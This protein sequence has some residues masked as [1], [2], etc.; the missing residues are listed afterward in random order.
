V[1]AL[2]LMQHYA[3][4]AHDDPRLVKPYSMA[5]RTVVLLATK[6]RLAPSARMSPSVAAT[7]AAKRERLSAYDLMEMEDDADDNN[8]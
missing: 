8:R 4:K 6:L 3:K 7:T 5:A 2:G 1:Q